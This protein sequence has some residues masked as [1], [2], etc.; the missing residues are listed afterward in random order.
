M[1][2]KQFMAHVWTWNGKMRLSVC[3]NESFYTETFVESFL[4]KVVKVLLDEL[5]RKGGRED[6]GSQIVSKER[7]SSFWDAQICRH[8]W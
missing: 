2:I 8:R 7:T 1:L 3:Y 4:E 5:A 6:V